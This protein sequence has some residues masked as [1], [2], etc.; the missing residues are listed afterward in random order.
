[1]SFLLGINRRENI[2]AAGEIILFLNCLSAPALRSFLRLNS[3]PALSTVGLRE[4]LS[5]ATRAQTAADNLGEHPRL[6]RFNY[7]F[8]RASSSSPLV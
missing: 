8:A 6:P 5:A 1:M 2:L 3:G 4:G 7:N